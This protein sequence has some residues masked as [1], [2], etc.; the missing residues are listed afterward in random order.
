MKNNTNLLWLEDTIPATPGV[1]DPDLLDSVLRSQKFRDWKARIVH[2]KA[3]GQATPVTE[4][5]FSATE[6]ATAWGVSAETVRTI[7]RIE[8]GVLRLEGQ[9]T[10]TRRRYVTLRIPQSVAERVHRRLSAIP[11]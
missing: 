6:L 10:K 1:V 8:P 5:H 4:K 9:Q 3:A 11:Q 7:F 2:R